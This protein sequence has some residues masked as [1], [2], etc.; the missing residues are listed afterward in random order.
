VEGFGSGAIPP[1]PYSSAIH[2]SVSLFYATACC[3]LFTILAAGENGVA[4]GRGRATGGTALILRAFMSAHGAS[5]RPPWPVCCRHLSCFSCG[6][7]DKRAGGRRRRPR[8][9]WRGRHIHYLQHASL[10]MPQPLLLHMQSKARMHTTPLFTHYTDISM[11]RRTLALT[12]CHCSAGRKE[13][14]WRGDLCRK[15]L[16]ACGNM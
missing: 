10:S 9:A 4:T 2:V 12:H 7:W 14:G 13:E 11:V 16:I 1:V 5:I 8:D 15:I 6:V 3:H